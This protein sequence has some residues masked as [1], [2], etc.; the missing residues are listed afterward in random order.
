MKNIQL[1]VDI[2]S[3]KFKQNKLRCDECVFYL[4]GGDFVSVEVQRIIF[5]NNEHIFPGFVVLVA[6][7]N[8][9]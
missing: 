6:L 1:N 8:G 2:R 7:K 5:A 4:S 3:L 9:E